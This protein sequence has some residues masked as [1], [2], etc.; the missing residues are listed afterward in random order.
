LGRLLHSGLWWIPLVFALLVGAVGGYAYRTLA[1]AMRDGLRADLQTILDADMAA[2]GLWAESHEAIVA[3][4]VREGDVRAEAAE[5][6]ELARSVR[7]R[8]ELAPLL[9]GAAAVDRLSENLGPVMEEKGYTAYALLGVDST[10]LAASQPPLIGHRVDVEFGRLEGLLAGDAVISQPVPAVRPSDP[11]GAPVRA[12]LRVGA[13]VL[14]PTGEVIAI[15]GFTLP[16]ED[17]SNVLRIARTGESGETYAFDADGLMLSHS[18]FEED[19]VEL[20]LLEPG[21]QSILRVQI[22]D[23]GGDLTQ[24]FVPTLPLK[25]RPLTRMAAAASSGE[26]GIDIDGYPDYRGVPVVGAWTWSPELDLGVTT[27]LDVSEAYA[28]LGVVRRSFAAIAGL[29]A[30][31]A[32]GMFGYSVLLGRVQRRYETARKLGRYRVVEKI[33]EGGMGKVYRAEHALL[34]RPTAVKLLESSSAG[35]EASQRFEREVQAAASLT[36]PNTI[37]IYDYG[38]T[39]DGAFYYAMEYLEGIDVAQLVEYDGPQPEARAVHLVRQAAS[40]VAEAHA[41]GMIHRDLKPSNLFL[42][43][44][45]GIVDFVKVL[46][47]G[48]V[49]SSEEDLQLTSHESLTGT[50]LYLSPE[51]LEAPETMDPRSDVYQLGAVLYTLLTGRPVFEGTS[52]VEVLSKHINTSPVPPSELL[53]HPFSADLE[54]LVLTCLAKDPEQR[55]RDA[56]ALRDALEGCVLEGPW[57]QAD[58]RAWWADWALRHPDGVGVQSGSSSLPS[59]WQVDAG[60]RLGRS[61]TGSRTRS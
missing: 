1:D 9:R 44:R 23:P 16:A 33:G 30:L 25:A 42:C 49:R 29:F 18:R 46:D 17:F 3:S 40:S 6:V 14:G 52:L 47:F 58:A 37:A 43:Q 41:A 60:G 19:L 55:P 10:V 27:E 22:R 24:G 7:T 21:Q 53:G 38:R 34:R 20:G 54:K 12:V 39:P 5:L 61:R 32:L 31:A 51:A 36:H 11:E 13:G 15:L 57:T 35:S 48:L 26:P 4:V 8:G 28:G 45:G 50:P 56:A 2:L 59:G